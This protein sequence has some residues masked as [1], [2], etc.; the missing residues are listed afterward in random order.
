VID[1]NGNALPNITLKLMPG[2]ITVT[3]DANGSF[4]FNN[5][6]PAQYKLYLVQKDNTELLCMDINVKK[7]MASLLPAI[8]Y[9]IDVKTVSVDNNDIHQE[10]INPEETPEYGVL[11]GFYY[12]KRGKTIPNGEIFLRGYGSVKTDKTG[13]FTFENIVPGEYELYTVL[14][15]GTEYIFRTVN[16]EPNKGIQVKIMEPILEENNESNPWLLVLIIGVSVVVCANI[17]LFIVLL[18]RKKK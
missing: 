17:V 12:T 14:D 6:T 5:L 11:R 15:D 10:Q 7:G 3:T 4:F 2:D 1:N 9:Y 13:M 18:S 8:T 16:I